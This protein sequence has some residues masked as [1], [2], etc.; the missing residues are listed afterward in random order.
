[1]LRRQRRLQ[2][3]NRCNRSCRSSGSSS[4]R[5]RNY[6]PGLLIVLL[7]LLQSFELHMCRQLMG[8]TAHRRHDAD[9]EAPL[10]PLEKRAIAPTTVSQP[11]E[12]FSAPNDAADMSYDEYPVSVDCHPHLPRHP[13]PPAPK[14]ESLRGLLVKPKS[15]SRFTHTICLEMYIFAFDCLPC[16]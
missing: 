14:F 6:L 13:L 11:E 4:W 1:M 16:R 12:I 3:D 10:L 8:V 7:V 15:V 9:K 5:S 2:L